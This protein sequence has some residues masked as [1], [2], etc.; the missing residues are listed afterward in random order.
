M[1][2]IWKLL[3]NVSDFACTS[4]LLHMVISTSTVLLVNCTS[5]TSLDKCK[6]M[7]TMPQSRTANASTGQG[8]DQALTIRGFFR[9]LGGTGSSFFAFGFDLGF[10]FDAAA[11]A[12]AAAAAAAA[13]FFSL[14]NLSALHS[15]LC[16]L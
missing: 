10:G 8:T 16:R 3:L 15:H 13:T 5:V 6:L 1:V 4:I 12:P 14:P 7:Q 9:R 2:L 11:V